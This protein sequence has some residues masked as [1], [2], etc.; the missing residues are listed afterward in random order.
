MKTHNFTFLF[1]LLL[2]SSLLAMS[3][4]GQSTEAD[5]NSDE[6]DQDELFSDNSSNGQKSGNPEFNDETPASDFVGMWHASQGVGSGYSESFL[7][8][9]NSSFTFH[10]NSMECDNPDLSFGGTYEI[11]NEK[12]IVLTVNQKEHVVGGSLEPSNGSC[13]TEYV[14]VGGEIV[15]EE[16]QESYQI[17]LK[18]S[19]F[20]LD[21]E[22][23][24]VP[25]YKFNDTRYWRIST[26][27][28]MYYW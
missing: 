26:N 10:R 19:G 1:V 6:L 28:E 2:I 25:T 11:V 4:S 21:E 12:L 5:K 13:A 16:L 17:E 3:C 7:F 20:Y 24:D 15:A 9:S 27:P 18:L 8:Y 22:Y 14:L 23:F